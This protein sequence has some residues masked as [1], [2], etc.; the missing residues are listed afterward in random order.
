MVEQQDVKDCSCL[1]RQGAR[2]RE[3]LTQLRDKYAEAQREM[4]RLRHSAKTKDDEVRALLA[5]KEAL[6]SEVRGFHRGS[7]PVLCPVLLL[8]LCAAGGFED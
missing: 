1:W 6:S 7:L 3:A 5:A 2:D 8:L 4:E